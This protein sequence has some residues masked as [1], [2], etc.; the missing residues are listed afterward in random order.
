MKLFG[1]IVGLSTLVFAKDYAVVVGIDHYQQQGVPHLVGAKNDAIHYKDLMLLNGLSRSNIK[2]L[3]NEN[4]TKANIQKALRCARDKVKGNDRF[5][6]FHA[7]HGTS[8]DDNR[9]ILDASTL[10]AINKTGILLPYDFKDG[11]LDSILLTQRD[12]RPYFEEI[13]KN[14]SFGLL[15]FDACFA[16]YAFRGFSPEQ[17]LIKQKLRAREYDAIEVPKKFNLKKSIVKYPYKNTYSLT[18]SD[19]T[20][21]SF[22]HPTEKRGIFSMALERCVKQNRITK[23]EGLKI[24]LDREYLT[25]VYKFKPPLNR[26]N[27]IFFNLKESRANINLI[28][29]SNLKSNN[30]SAFVNFVK[31]GVY[32]LELIYDKGVYSLNDG[33]GMLINEFKTEN[34]VAHYLSNYRF[35]HKKGR[36][37]SDIKVKMGDSDFLSIGSTHRATVRSSKKG[38]LAIF[39]MNKEGNLYMLEPINSYISFDKTYTTGELGIEAPQGTDFLKVILFEKENSLYKLKVDKNGMLLNDKEQIDILLNTLNYSRFYEITKKIRII[40]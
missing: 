13:D 7:G 6:Y 8:L 1:L 5:Y 9:D 18:S 19:S 20:H 37:G 4:A 22:E 25:Q 29:K 21:Q 17:K 39:S 11:D 28:V 32:D 26:N 24:C 15:T 40:R 10:I 12:L 35:I 27:P 36:E 16:G 2:L 31:E 14:I 33:F 23:E 34:E 38:F 30:F 3:V